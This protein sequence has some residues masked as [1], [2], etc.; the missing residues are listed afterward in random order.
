MEPLKRLWDRARRQPMRIVLCESDDARVRAAAQRAAA[1]GLAR[2]TLVGPPTAGGACPDCDFIDPQASPWIEAFA[3][4]MAELSQKHGMT[5]EQAHQAVLDP[6]TFSMLMVRLGHADGSVAGATH[7][8]ADV[9]R[10][11][12]RIIGM[13]P[14]SRL[15][16]SFFV[17]MREQPFHGTTQAMIFS[18][19]GLVIDPSSEQLA[20]IA[21]AGAESARRLLGIEPKLAMLSFS[22][23]HSASHSEVEKVRDATDM[24]R[25]RH[26]ELAVDGEIQLDA[27]IVPEIAQRKLPDS[28]IGGAA[29][30]LIFPNLAAGN[31]GYKLAE[32]LGQAVA[33]GPLLQGLNRPANDLSRGCAEDDIYNVIAITGIQAQPQR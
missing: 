11:A 6:L 15:V 12:I 29:N 27:A 28:H 31:I 21:L 13:H 23:N 24:I 30:V 16:S 17:M 7:T 8:T 18:D 33:F 9:V 5:M 19:C 1:D 2:V 20:E 22:T 4:T 3:Q 14:D 26:P 25:S 32:R 10:S